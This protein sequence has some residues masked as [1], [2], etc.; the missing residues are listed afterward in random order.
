MHINIYVIRK[1]ENIENKV[2]EAKAIRIILLF[3]K[4]HPAHF[5][6]LFTLQRQRHLNFNYGLVPR[7]VI[8]FRYL[9]IF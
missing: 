5:T 1:E 4:R 9:F 2:P 8:L 6:T 7:N 3:H